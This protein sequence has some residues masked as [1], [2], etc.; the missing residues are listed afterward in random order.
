VP[1]SIEAQG[2]TVDEAIQIALNQLGVSRDSVEIEILHHPR[3]GFLGIGARRAKIRA[4]VRKHFFQDGEEYDMGV[5]E[6]SSRSRRGRRQSRRRRGGRSTARERSAEDERQQP[7]GQQRQRGS[8]GAERAAGERRTGESRP[9]QRSG[10]GSGSEPVERSNEA[11]RSRSRRRRGGQEGRERQ[12]AGAD[13]ERRVSPPSAPAREPESELPVAAET[14]VVRTDRPEPRREQ[15]AVAHEEAAVVETAA[16]ETLKL[17]REEVLA[18]SVTVVDEL[19]RRMGFT[20]EVAADFDEVDGE[21]LVRVRSDAEGL[22]IGRRGQTLDAAEHL[23]N[24]MVFAGEPASENR[25]ALDIGGYRDRRREALVELAGRL[26]A[27][28]TSERRRVQVSPMNPRD[29]KILQ[30]ALA[31]DQTVETRILGSGFYRRVLICPVG[32]TDDSPPIDEFSDDGA[33]PDAPVD[34]LAPRGGS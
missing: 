14:Q 15:A 10:K 9:R 24:R 2:V 22:L 21:V 6:R 8:G 31:A 30:A 34:E 29:R 17:S 27:R 12:A 4:T 3:S 16:P 20:A 18:R 23:V 13:P 7:V 28:A 26:K 25:I 32:L 19:L 33:A 5:G 11:S 1:T